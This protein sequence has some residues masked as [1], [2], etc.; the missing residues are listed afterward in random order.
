MNDTHIIVA[1]LTLSNA[2][3]RHPEGGNL[4]SWSISAEMFAYLLFPLF[5]VLLTKRRFLGSVF[6]IVLGAALYALVAAETGSLDVIGGIAPFRCLAGFLLGMLIFQYR[7]LFDLP[8][9]LLTTVQV[10][11]GAVTISFIATKMNDIA[12]VPCFVI[13]VGTTWQD[14]GS[15]AQL[16]AT[17]TA[18]WLGDISF[19]VYLNH[20]VLLE[21]LEVPWGSITRMMSLDPVLVRI[22]WLVTSL[23][24]VL[25]V[26]QL[27]RTYIEVPFQ[28]R[29]G[30]LLRVTKRLT[31]SPVA[32]S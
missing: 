31:R 7:Q 30:R 4:P 14:R 18:V 20:T 26:S 25:V 3:L 28:R 12:L 1:Q 9:A 16:L 5:I 13:L 8:H 21:L 10:I 24:L 29:L 23:T 2:W 19:S 32:P 15:V 6:A 11:V 27:T 17:P 22:G